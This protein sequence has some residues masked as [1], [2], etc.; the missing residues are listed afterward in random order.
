M[1]GICKDIQNWFSYMINACKG[2]SNGL[3]YDHCLQKY[4]QLV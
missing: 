1:I 4:T 2:I 3:I